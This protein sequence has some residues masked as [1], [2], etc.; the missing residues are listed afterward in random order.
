[1]NKNLRTKINEMIQQNILTDNLCMLCIA[2]LLDKLQKGGNPK[3]YKYQLKLIT[4]L[5]INKS[6]LDKSSLVE[7]VKTIS[8]RDFPTY[9]VVNKI[10][11]AIEDET[12]KYSDELISDKWILYISK[13]ENSN[14][15]LNK[16]IPLCNKINDTFFNG[17]LNYTTQMKKDVIALGCDDETIKKTI[18]F[19]KSIIQNGIASNKITN[20]TLKWKYIMTAVENRLN[21]TKQILKQT[22]Q[23]EEKTKSIDMTVAT[24]KSADYKRKT[25]D[26]TNKRL[27]RMW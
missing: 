11:C 20:V 22:K 13:K 1:M 26:V 5:L 24:H 23:N 8:S 15:Q 17:I 21:E 6:N 3:P 12:Y 4:R 10:V 2:R 18:D 25:V 9:E 7:K 14:E 19:N 27:E 16:A